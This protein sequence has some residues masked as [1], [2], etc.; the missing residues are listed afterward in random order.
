[1]MIKPEYLS[2][3]KQV[4]SNED[5]SIQRSIVQNISA[6]LHTDLLSCAAAMLHLQSDNAINLTLTTSL[7]TQIK[8]EIPIANNVL[9]IKMLRYRLE[10]G[11]NHQITVEQLKD[12]LVSESGVDRNNINVIG[13][14]ADYTIIELPDEMPTDIFQHLKS[15][16][17]N[18]QI[19]DL[20]RLK[21]RSKKRNNNRFRRGRQRNAQGTNSQDS[22]DKISRDL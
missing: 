6:E 18:Q 13:I 22:S 7:S 19:L 9:A 21:N 3:L 11:T 17:L 14:H 15:L 4:L 8:S 20:K 1:M 2:K 5:L 10:V 12:L 16:E